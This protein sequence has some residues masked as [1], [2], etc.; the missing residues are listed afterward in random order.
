MGSDAVGFLGLGAMGLP[1]A[2][3]LARSGVPLL[4]WN[5][6]ASRAEPLRA[7]GVSIAAHAEDVFREATIVLAM[8]ADERAL[9]ETLG[10][11][12]SDFEARISGR[13]LVNM[14][15]V[16]TRY[17]AELEAEIVAAGGRYAEAPVSGLRLP[18][19]AG[20]LLGLVAGHPDAVEA[21]TPLL[22]P[23]CA[24]VVDCGAVPKAMA[25]KC[26]VNIF[27]IGSITAL[28]EATH[29]ARAQALDAE[30]F[31][32]LL[33]ASQMASEISRAKV[34]KLRA[35]DLA[36]H[37]AIA[38]VLQTSRLIVQSADTL[39]VPVPLMDAC[40]AL[41]ADASAR[42]LDGSDMIAVVDAFPRSVEPD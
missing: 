42:G 21:A 5:R 40:M 15:T 1:M 27:L 20:R 11:G 28:A 2:R 4:A 23:M 39:G 9:D 14:A 41:Y 24:S 3:N 22:R 35:G 17:S 12:T 8:L 29:Y 7:E 26:A 25:M 19:E 13:L 32:S 31:F 37:A 18:A 10:R 16:S 30:R 38:N 36:P 34:A 6:T 33:D